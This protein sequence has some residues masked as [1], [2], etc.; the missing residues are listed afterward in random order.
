VRVIPVDARVREH[1]AV[2]EAAADRANDPSPIRVCSR[3]GEGSPIG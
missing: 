3:I 1:Q 2:G